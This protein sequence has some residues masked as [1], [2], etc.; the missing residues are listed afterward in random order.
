MAEGQCPECGFFHPPVTRGT[1]PMVQAKKIDEIKEATKSEA[2]RRNILSFQEEML[3]LLEGFPDDEII[4]ICS[5]MKN[6]LYNFA[7]QRKKT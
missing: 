7:L 6:M 5:Q 4:Q 1:C 2:L 3:H